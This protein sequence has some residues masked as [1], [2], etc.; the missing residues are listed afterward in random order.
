M[1]NYFSKLAMICEIRNRISTVHPYLETLYP[2][3]VAEGNRLHVFEPDDAGEQY[4]FSGSFPVPVPVPEGFRA[5]FNLECIDNRMACVVSADVFDSLDGYSTIFHE[6]IHCKQ[7]EYEPGLKQNLSIAVEAKKS[8]DF[9]WELNHAFPYAN[10][11][12]IRLYRLFLDA[13]GKN[14]FSAVLES[15]LKLAE[16]LPE[17]DYEYIIWQEWKEGFARLVENR[18][19][20]KLGLPAIQY[21]PERQID[22][23]NF[24]QGGASLIE[25]LLKRE[26]SLIVHIDR[27][28]GV[29]FSPSKSSWKRD[30]L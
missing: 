10:H 5:A 11:E 28:F 29:M 30:V 3:A 20:V 7:A 13:S 9:M 1:R 14:G 18:I 12:F 25:F 2:V 21:K 4:A 26:P 23:R 15:R 19:R 17:K 27:L 22:R 16:L 8:G 6:F 24:Y